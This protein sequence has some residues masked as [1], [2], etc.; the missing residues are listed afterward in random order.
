MSR[1]KKDTALD[2]ELSPSLTPVIGAVIARVKR[3]FDLGASPDA[4][5]ALLRKIPCWRERC[6]GF[7]ACGWRE[8]STDSNSRF[9]PF[10]ANRFP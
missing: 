9:A 6:A 7:R 10:W 1:G 4:V 3:L 5:S 2:V 8:H